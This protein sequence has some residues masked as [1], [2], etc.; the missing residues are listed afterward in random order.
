MKRR[1]LLKALCALPFI[2]TLRWVPTPDPN[3]YSMV[4]EA[5]GASVDETYHRLKFY[6]A[7]TS[8]VDSSALNDEIHD[9][10]MRLVPDVTEELFRG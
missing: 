5:N 10:T 4:V 3:P 6:M 2:P 1:T 8:V 9:I 7:H